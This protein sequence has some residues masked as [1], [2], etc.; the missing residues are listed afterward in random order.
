MA[1]NP[2]TGDAGVCAKKMSIRVMHHNCYTVDV[3]KCDR[4][5]KRRKFQLLI[6]KRHQLL[7]GDF[8]VVVLIR[9]ESSRPRRMQCCSHGRIRTRGEDSSLCQKFH[10]VVDTL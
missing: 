9:N 2:D 8:L 1:P 3:H 5:S 4:P 10:V 7:R 6:S